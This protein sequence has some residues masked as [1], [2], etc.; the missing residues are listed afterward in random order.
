MI[1]SLICFDKL[2]SRYYDPFSGRFLNADAY[3]STGQGILGNNMYAYCGNNPISRL[4]SSGQFWEIVVAVI[5]FAAGYVWSSCEVKEN[6]RV[7][8]ELESLPEPSKDISKSFRKTLRENAAEVKEISASEGFFDSCI[9]F[10]NKVRNKGE[11]D[12]KQYDE[13]K[14]TFLFNGLVVQGQD[15]GNINFG[16]T[17]K[18]L[19]LPDEILLAGA[20]AAQIMAGTSTPI[21]LIVSYGDDLRDQLFIM[22]GILLYKIDNKG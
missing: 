2:A 19:G 10:Y 11:W 22:Y 18:A 13:Y 16:Y 21:S 8:K 14:G 4:D 17:G 6:E 12:L 3:A 1:S 9:A 7:N 15:V 5:A 20:G